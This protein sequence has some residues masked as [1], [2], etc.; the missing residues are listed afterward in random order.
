MA[1]GRS[2]RDIRGR[3]HGSSDEA[4]C[5]WCLPSSRIKVTPPSFIFSDSTLATKGNLKPRRLRRLDTS[6]RPHNHLPSEAAQ[7]PTISK[8][9]LHRHVNLKAHPDMKRKCDSFSRQAP[10]APVRLF[11][12]TTDVSTVTNAAH[13]QLN[14]LGYAMVQLFTFRHHASYIQGVTGGTDQ[15][16]GGCSLC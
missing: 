13:T 8:R 12:S 5:R 9:R 4:L 3:H 16:S 11:L 14:I 7:H 2:I 6:K 15:T 10:P 1:S